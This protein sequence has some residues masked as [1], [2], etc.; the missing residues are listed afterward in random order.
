MALN[1]S[2]SLALF[3][4]LSLVFSGPA[5]PA[6]EIQIES[7]V[8]RRVSFDRYLITARLIN[9]TNE[10]REV[11]LHAQLS[12]YDKTAPI[13]DRPVMIIRKELSVVLKKKQTKKFR[14]S[15]INEG[16]QPKAPMR[17]EP[18]L[19]VQRQKVWNH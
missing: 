1:K 6:E 5:F 12:F 15:L 3:F 17:F 4:F 10:P 11:T 19:R 14:V 8:S 2:R 16:V 7:I 9:A 13:G 18:I